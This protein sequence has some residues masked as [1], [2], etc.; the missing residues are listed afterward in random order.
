MRH[1]S[2]FCRSHMQLKYDKRLTIADAVPF[3]VS[4]VFL[5][6]PS[7]HDCQKPGRITNLC[8]SSHTVFR[9]STLHNSAK[10]SLHHV[11]N[12]GWA[13]CL[14]SW[15]SASSPEALAHVGRYTHEMCK[16]QGLCTIDWGRKRHTVCDIARPMAAMKSCSTFAFLRHTAPS[17]IRK[18]QMVPAACRL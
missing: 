1:A 12:W 7:P 18:A 6:V 17:S 2:V 14:A 5:K 16:V 8:L 11:S 13:S 10:F 9:P 3:K 4:A 15:T